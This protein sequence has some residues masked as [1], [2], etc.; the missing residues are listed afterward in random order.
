MGEEGEGTR[1]IVG[2]AE[3]HPIGL[4]DMGLYIVRVDITD[5]AISTLQASTMQA[6]ITRGYIHGTR[7]YRFVH[8]DTLY[9]YITTMGKNNNRKTRERTEQ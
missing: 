4:V 7:D 1:A 8:Q 3:A 6:R 9:D 5:V 2:R